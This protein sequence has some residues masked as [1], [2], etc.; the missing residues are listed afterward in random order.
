VKSKRRP[1]AEIFA[2]IKAGCETI[3]AAYNQ[4]PHTQHVW[5]LSGSKGG[6]ENSP[7]CKLAGAHGA[8][9]AKLSEAELTLELEQ[10][11]RRRL[12]VKAELAP[13]RS[14]PGARIPRGH[15]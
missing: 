1:F 12:E 3:A 5:E 6:Y 8:L 2:E 13:R 11:E 7:A 10:V 4:L 9:L 14:S 15:R